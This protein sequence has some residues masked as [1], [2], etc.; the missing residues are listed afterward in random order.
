MNAP[1]SPSMPPRQTSRNGRRPGRTTLALLVALLLSSGTS[2]ADLVIDMVVEDSAPTGSTG[3]FDVILAVD[4]SSTA[5]GTTSYSL[6]SFG[7]EVSVPGGSGV[8]IT[9]AD[10]STT[11]PYVFAPDTSLAQLI[12]GTFYANSSAGDLADSQLDDATL[13]SGTL[14]LGVARFYYSVSP[15]ASGIVPVTL[16]DVTGA[17]VQTALYDFSGAP[18][19]FTPMNGQIDLGAANSIIPEPSSMLMAASAGLIVLLRFLRGR[20][21][22]FC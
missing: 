6:D 16:A 2:R 1:M 22:T 10:M 12:P 20:R 18:I 8:T 15:G 13:S 19:P 21:R 3:F 17:N 7:V 11:D 14:P 9:G 5:M 4:A